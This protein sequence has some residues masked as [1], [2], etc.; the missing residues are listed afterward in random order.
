VSVLREFCP[1]CGTS[2]AAGIR[3]RG[4]GT[5]GGRPPEEL[6]RNRK[7]VFMVGAGI[8]ILLGVAGKIQPFWHLSIPAHVSIGGD[9]RPR[10]PVTIRAEQLYDAYQ[11][12]PGSADSRFGGREM[13]VSGAFV[14][15]VPDGYGS[16]DMRL[17]TSNP[18][19]PLGIDLDKVSID[20]ATKLEP[21]EDVTVSCRRVAQTGDERWLQDCVIQPPAG[22]NAGPAA[23]PA[24]APP[25]ASAVSGGNS[26]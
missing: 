13:V 6:M 12:D 26:G 19:A 25:A 11:S 14:R 7:T 16:I 10:A 9:S 4:F 21:G 18:Q 24:P 20:M 17:K 3:E 2:V 22:G 1:K 15:T 8:L 23:P 5:P